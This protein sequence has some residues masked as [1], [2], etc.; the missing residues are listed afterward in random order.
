MFSIAHRSRKPGRE[1]PAAGAGDHR[2][3]APIALPAM[4]PEGC[5]AAP[6]RCEAASAA[7]GSILHLEC[8]YRGG[9]L[10]GGGRV[11]WDGPIRCKC[12]PE[13]PLLSIGVPN[14][15]VETRQL[16]DPL[17]HLRVRVDGAVEVVLIEESMSRREIHLD[18]DG[19]NARQ[20]PGGGGRRVERTEFQ[21]DRHV[22]SASPPDGCACLRRLEPGPL[23]GEDPPAGPQS[24]E[25]ESARVVGRRFCRAVGWSLGAVCPITL[26]PPIGSPSVPRTIPEMMA[27]CVPAVAGAS[28]ARVDTSN[29]TARRVAT[30]SGDLIRAEH[31]DTDSESCAL[32]G[33]GRELRPDH[34][35]DPGRSGGYRPD[36]VCHERTPA[37]AARRGRRGVW[38]SL[39]ATR[40]G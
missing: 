26:A 39:G 38:I 8:L 2:R 32:L 20:R 34:T 29:S 19:S 22:D 36:L 35:A 25:P 24:D 10:S 28:Q 40:T 3:G 12:A 5:Q 30:P 16:G 27:D 1:R 18:V 17:E 9:G 15:Q 33:A 21:D 23:N 6:L 13:V 14:L 4:A 11:G 31:A 7:G 37:T